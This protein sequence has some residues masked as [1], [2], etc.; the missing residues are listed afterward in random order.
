MASELHSVEIPLIKTLSKLGWDFIPQN[1]NLALRGGSED[2]V[3]LKEYVIEAILKYNRSKG[4]TKEDAETIYRK[5]NRLEN[6]EEFYTWLKGEKSQKLKDGK[7]VS[8]EFYDRWNPENN[9]FSVTQQFTCTITKPED[10]KKNIR[11]DLVLFLNGIPLTVVE[12]KFLG[13][14]GSTYGEGIKQLERYQRTTPKLFYPNVFN[15]TTDGLKLKY[16]ATGATEQ[17]YLEWKHD[18]G[19]PAELKNNSD[20]QTYAKENRVN[21]NPFIDIQVFGLLN[22]ENYIDLITNFVVFET[23]ENQ[24]V[25][26]IARFQ[27]VRAV[28]KI[29][30]RVL[31]GKM[32][33]G[34][35]WHTQGSGKSLTMLFASWK[36]RTLP[37]LKNPTILIVVDRVDLDEQIS[38]TFEAVKL[39]NT[40]R[41]SSIRA[42]RDKLKNDTREVIITT[43]FKFDEM[44]DILIDRKNVIVLIDEAHRT[45]EGKNAAQMRETLQNGF[46]FGFTGTPID[47]LDKNTHRNFGLKPDGTV[48]RYMD[49]YNIKDAIDDKATVPVHYQLRN[50]KWH[51]NSDH[52]DKLIDAE[53]S[54]LSEEELDVL[55]DKGSSYG[56]TF[57][58]NPERLKT[59][60]E[61]IVSHYKAY[62]EPNGYKAQ[63]VAFSREACV[64]IKEHIDRLLGEEYSDVVYS[65]GQN[66]RT[67]LRKYHKSKQEIRN[68][69]KVF[70]QKDSKLKFII[71]QSMLLTGF[72]APIEQVMYLD[73]PLK[74]HSLLQAIAR[75]NRPYPNKKCGIIIDYCG[76]LKNLKKALNFDESDVTDCLIDFDKLKEQLPKH[77]RDFHNS[78]AASENKSPYGIADFLH[79]SDN[80]ISFK[81]AYKGV[82]I[83]Y[84]TLAP[85]PF[86]LDYT[87][88]Y[89]E[90]TKLKLIVDSILIQLPPDVSQYLAKTREIIQAH[91]DIGDINEQAPVFVVD[92]NYLKRLDG[93]ALNEKDKELTLENRLRTVLRIKA[94]DLPVYK[95]LQE[96]LEQVIK[97]RDED[98]E[99]SYDLL[100]Q[101]MLEFNEAQVME[102]D[103]TQTMGERAITQMLK[104]HINNDELVAIITQKLNAAVLRETEGFTNWQIQDS[105]VARIRRDIIIELAQLSKVH[106]AITKETIDYSKFAEEVM[107]YILQ[108][109]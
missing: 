90:A 97:R 23:K 62:V 27:Q 36:L 88:E 106:S 1:E 37:Q 55:K 47:K 70:K 29:V 91:I 10:A 14:E 100:R 74:D 13:T 67:P 80:L 105:V 9:R 93:T 28:N 21:Y 101:I 49:L 94:D 24:T 68:C 92:D 107:K 76:I 60:A 108:Y 109:Y 17:Y 40:T 22:R 86:V 64:I 84:E 69:I 12:C 20:F 102:E 30:D 42:L 75:T 11:P 54:H 81:E 98:L 79:K 96:R 83:S 104:E 39:P 18:D 48:E 72:D 77:L 59:I 56:K 66:D 89:V 57:M 25:K 71:V 52:I 33:S 45:Q 58:M 4:L 35:I 50:E 43:I 73:R 103:D 63:I 6:N 53:F 78:Y 16:G 95:T 5:L 32:H 8:V 34:L 51:I 87:K 85:D 3:F 61:D 26:M 41:A 44:R 15:I 2:E 46:L 7:S 65:P 99:D 31:E 19:T 82:Q 38:G